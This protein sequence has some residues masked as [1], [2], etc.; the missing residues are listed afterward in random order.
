MKNVDNSLKDVLT[1]S[2]DEPLYANWFRY[3]LR[4]PGDRYDSQ[5]IENTKLQSIAM[6]QQGILVKI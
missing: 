1:K 3:Y 6:Q 5:F 2:L 4:L